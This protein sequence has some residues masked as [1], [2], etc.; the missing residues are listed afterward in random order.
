MR[1]KKF[2]KCVF[3]FAYVAKKAYL[4]SRK[5]FGAIFMKNLGL[6]VV[7][8]LSFCGCNRNVKTI[9]GVPVQGTPWELA[10]AINDKGDQSFFPESVYEVS[11]NKAYISGV[12]D[13][14]AIDP[15]FIP[16]PDDGG[17]LPA[18]IVCEV[19]DGQVVDA[20]IYCKH[21]DKEK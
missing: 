20:F 14:R 7:I 18:E 5:G 8:I 17:Y 15:S 16:S 12:V 13:P 10:A 3:L 1:F 19:K 2:G 4:C 9:C 6:L 11:D 21:L